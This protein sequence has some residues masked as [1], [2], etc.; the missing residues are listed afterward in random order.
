M[1][2]E[3]LA[4]MWWRYIRT[5]TS[6]RRAAFQ[7]FSRFPFLLPPFSAS[8]SPCFIVVIFQF[9]RRHFSHCC[10]RRSRRLSITDLLIRESSRYNWP[11]NPS[12]PPPP[13]W[14]F[15]LLINGSIARTWRDKQFTLVYL[16]TRDNSSQLTIKTVNHSWY[17]LMEI[18]E[19]VWWY[20]TLIFIYLYEIW[21]SQF[22]YEFINYLL[23]YDITI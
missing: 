7:Q 12:L 2:V 13:P 8:L 19:L 23:I 10:Q 3:R 4:S 15:I 21:H 18:G 9:E 22:A 16:L 20:F 1:L 6:S 5:H 11:F 14:K 17:N